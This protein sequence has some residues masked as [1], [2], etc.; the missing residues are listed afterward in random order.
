MRAC[1]TRSILSKVFSAGLLCHQLVPAAAMPA[2][3]MTLTSLFSDEMTN[4]AMA[5]VAAIAMLAVMINV[6]ALCGSC[7]G[8][9]KARNGDGGE[10][11]APGEM[12]AFEAPTVRFYAPLP[13]GN[14]YLSQWTS[15]CV[16]A[17]RSF[18]VV[19]VC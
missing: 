16:C 5:V 18:L 11:P 12:T 1:T 4:S 17:G 15:M 7:F 3:R 8:R 9:N 10:E 13:F 6:I 14:A 19:G 2:A